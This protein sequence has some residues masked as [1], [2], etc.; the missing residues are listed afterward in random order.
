MNEFYVGKVRWGV[1]TGLS[2]TRAKCRVGRMV[3]RVQEAMM[4]GFLVAVGGG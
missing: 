4:G 3:G 2:W 1:D